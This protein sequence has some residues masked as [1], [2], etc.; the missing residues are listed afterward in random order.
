MFGKQALIW[1]STLSFL[2]PLLGGCS[3]LRVGGE[4]QSGRQA[5]L[6]GNADAAVRYLT[7]AAEQNPKYVYVIENYRESVWTELGRAQYETKRYP[8]ARQSFE[9]ALA[10]NRDDSMARLYLGVLLIRS[11]QMHRGEKN[12]KD[13]M[14]GLSDWIEYMNRTQPFQAFWDPTH[15][16]RK[17]IDQALAISSSPNVHR[18]QM[19]ADAEWIGKKFEEELDNVRDDERREFERDNEK[20]RLS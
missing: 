4:F 18:Q 16:I 5:L 9:K 3:T 12:L 19:I 1:L 14:N 17:E 11:G 13:G 10:M 8:E 2:I 15:E 6:K 20:D 7:A